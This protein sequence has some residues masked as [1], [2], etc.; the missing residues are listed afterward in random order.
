M[1]NEAA[2]RGADWDHD[3]WKAAVLSR[4]GC[5][6]IAFVEKRAADRGAERARFLRAY[7]AGVE[8]CVTGGCNG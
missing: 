2:R 6:R 4:D 5:G 7:M 3:G 8:D 1:W